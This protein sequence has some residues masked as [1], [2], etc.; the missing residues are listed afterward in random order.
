M[1]TTDNGCN[2]CCAWGILVV[3]MKQVPVLCVLR[4][5]TSAES[6]VM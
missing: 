4:T 1:K 2:L 3:M 6:K 5:T